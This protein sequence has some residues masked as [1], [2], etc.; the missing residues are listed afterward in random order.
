MANIAKIN[1]SGLDYNIKDSLAHEHFVDYENPH[2]VTKAQIGLGNVLDLTPEQLL[3]EYL[4][5]DMINAALGYTP[6]DSENVDN[7]IDKTVDSEATAIVNFVN[8]IKLNG[9]Y[10][11]YD[12]TT[13]TVTFS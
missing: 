1:V 11:R 2:R 3:K 4:K 12:A 9:A 6:G 13:N 7:K 10:M 5:A 8:G